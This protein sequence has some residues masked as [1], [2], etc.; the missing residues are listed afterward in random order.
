ALADGLDVRCSIV[1]EGIEQGDNGVTVHTSA[2]PFTGSHVI[3]TV[4]LGV[5]KAGT[6]RFDPALPDPH[7]AAIDRVGFGAFEKVA[8][9]YDRPVWQ[10]DGTPTHLTVVDGVLPEW[11]VVLDMSTWY[12]SPVVV[13]L[14][15][16]DSARAL[17]AM[18]EDAKV[19]SLHQVIEV[20]GGAG[21]P[22]PHHHA[23]TSWTNDPFLLG[24][25]TNISPNSTI[26][27]QAVDVGTLAT[28]HGR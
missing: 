26:D 19:R 21:T 6:V 12:G 25:Y 11:P 14:A 24:C 13:G 27:E 10:T 20:I 28:P 9:E 18:D 4:P 17:A 22:P 3:V 1:V 8:L 16:G 7:L 5:L 2:G 15:V 23:V